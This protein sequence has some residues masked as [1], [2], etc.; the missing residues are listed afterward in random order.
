M[1]TPQQRDATP[2]LLPDLDQRAKP[3][4][5]VPNEDPLFREG[6]LQELLID[7]PK[8]L[9]V[10][11]IEPAYAPLVCLGSEISTPSGFL[12]VL[13]VSPTG[14]LTLVEAKMWDNPEARREVVGQIVEY[15]KDFSQWGFE[16]LDKAVRKADGTDSRGILER[17]QRRGHDVDSSS[18]IDT[19]TR[20]LQRGEFLLLVVGNGIRENLKSLSSYLQGTPNL[21]FS[22]RLVELALFRLESGQDWPLLVQPRV[23]ARTSEVTRAVV[24]VNAADDVEVTVDLPS[25]DEEKS[26]SRQTL[27]NAAFYEQLAENTSPDVA[28]EVRAL[29]GEITELGPKIKPRSSSFS[30][31]LPDPGGL[32]RA[33]TVVV[34]GTKGT[35]NLGWLNRISEEGGYDPEIWK[36]YLEDVGSLTGADLKEG[37]TKSPEPI[38]NLLQNREEYVDLVREFVEG[39]QAAAETR[40]K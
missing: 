39:L 25:E 28:G 37:G 22:L 14:Y 3:L 27:S 20:K 13:Y 6:R 29:T 18:F 33:W 11:E 26:S 21:H 1:D 5:P 30:L 23:V 38:E 16:D 32:D 9:P 12:D 36:S 7:H 40:E 4:E 10:S 34:L 17:V 15:A 19:V 2:L 24:D 35:F 31:R 8:A